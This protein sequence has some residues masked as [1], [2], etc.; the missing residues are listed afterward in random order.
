[1]LA[2]GIGSP[3]EAATLNV[4]GDY[5]TIQ[6][7][8]DAADDGDTVQ[9]AA[10]IYYENL[11]Y[12]ES[13]RLSPLYPR[14]IALVGAGRDVTIVNGGGLGSCLLMVD[15]PATASVEGFTF[16]GGA[17]G[18]P[19]IHVFNSV[20][21]LANNTITGS[22]GN[23]LST[24]AWPATE[25]CEV[26]LT[27]NSIVGNSGSG[28]WVYQ[29]VV[30]M[31]ENNISGNSGGGVHVWYSSGPFTRNTISEN[32]GTGMDLYKSSATLTDNV[33]SGNSAPVSSGM[34]SVG[35]GG[36]LC[37]NYSSVTMSGNQVIG[38]SAPADHGNGGGMLAFGSSV[39]MN[40]DLISENWATNEG[41]GLYFI[42]C[43]TVLEG[44]AVTGNYVTGGPYAE[45][46]MAGGAFFIDCTGTVSN[47][48]ISGNSA[49]HLPGV[50]MH[51]SSL[52]LADNI[53]TGNSADP[54]EYAGSTAV[55]GYESS[56]ILTRNT[57]ADNAG[58]GISFSHSAA[59]V[60]NSIIL[61]NALGICVNDSSLELSD[62]DILGNSG[63]GVRVVGVTLAMLTNSIIAGNA[64]AGVDNYA[65]ELVLTNNT[66][67]GNGGGGVTTD[68]WSP[69]IITNCILWGNTLE[70]EP[71]DLAGASATYSD[72]GAGE[73]EG[74]GNISLDPLFV[75]AAAGDFHLQTGSPC[76]DAGS[77]SAPA[78]PETDKDGN[79]RIFGPAVD[80]GAY[81][82]H[83]R[84]PTVHASCAGVVDEGGTLELSVTGDDPDGDELTYAWDLDGDGEF[85]TPGQMVT[86]SAVGL[87][88]PSTVT[89]SVQV[90]DGTD[91]GT[92]D[93]TI[94][95]LNVAPVVGGITGPADPAEV[96]ASVEVSAAFT[97][98]GVPDT[99]TAEW[100]WG[101]GSTSAG[102]VQETDGSGTV[103]GSHSYATPGV[104]T[105]TLTVTD[106][107]GGSD[108][109]VFSYVVVYDPAGGF[110]TGGG[111]IMSPAG[112]YTPDPS[113]TG[114]ATFGFVAKYKKG[115]NVPEGQT[116]FR[117]Q[118]GD[119]NFRSTS[120]QWLVVAGA[121]AKFKGR[122]TI[123]GAG[124][125]GFML[126]AT[127]G[128][129]SGGGGVDKFRIKITDGDGVVYDN[130][131]GLP[132]DSNEAT[133][134]GGGSIVV[135]KGG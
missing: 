28:V 37:I 113:L 78:L 117:F 63:T 46:P 59:T 81:E 64:G 97:D 10:G 120:Y 41:A 107:D 87:D 66:I 67:V 17:V 22:A 8:I 72:I 133:A 53:I 5:G 89:V 74:E 21:T 129:V 96:A 18:N 126:T 44:V 14:G 43:P 13:D 7:A 82:L 65:E 54:A 85:E 23:G 12:D 69:T 2:F 45:Y 102:T 105:V 58:W 124:D 119:L 134:I 88:G 32:A 92:D 100:D 1:L 26:T 118:A 49:P 71:M 80:M 132:D 93:A 20:A 25:T 3:A 121:H 127:D 112:A 68:W 50:T 60:T 114:K 6:A 16:T 24:R 62:S 61:N 101:D 84:P 115:A 109:S 77:N 130:K 111:W 122:G 57:I 128:Q 42:K 48:D 56:L 75:D 108:E 27:G 125:Y 99:H 51:G 35:S 33:I 83:N 104:Y 39:T 31:T 40:G 116:E 34:P 19:N 15:V 11:V 94:D 52:T 103:T 76:I 30:T 90:S 98:P 86:F 110:V 106:D 4:P 38:N 131:M 29:T 91:T 36:G 55:Q 47:S 9:V 95:V 123:N 73:T 70:S 79:P 135:H